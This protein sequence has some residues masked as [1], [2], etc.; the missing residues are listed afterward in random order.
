MEMDKEHGIESNYRCTECCIIWEKARKGM[1][2]LEA[3][4]PGRPS[5]SL[6]RLSARAHCPGSCHLAQRDLGS[7]A[8]CLDPTIRSKLPLWRAVMR[9]CL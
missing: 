3:G 6:F 5:A 4:F 2:W 7:L 9:H 8:V 1:S